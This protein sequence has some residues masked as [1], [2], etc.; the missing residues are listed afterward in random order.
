MDV[1]IR[2][3]GKKFQKHWIFSHINYE[4]KAG[5][6]YAITGPNGSGKS[7]LLQILTGFLPAS[8]GEVVYTDKDGK[9]VGPEDYFKHIAFTSPYMELIEEFTLEEMI[10]FHFKFKK[11]IDG[12]NSND[13]IDRMFLN[14]ARHKRI[15]VFSSGMKQRVKLGLAFF[16]DTPLLFLDEP[17]TNLDEKGRIWYEKEIEN[18]DKNRLLLVSSNIKREYNFCENVL[19]L[20]NYKN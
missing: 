8:K 1:Y 2:D 9:T 11:T 12:L 7:T 14:D 5:N 18:I 4:F 13:L 15:K 3:L 20:E 10:A 19:N 16:S 17:T 6:A